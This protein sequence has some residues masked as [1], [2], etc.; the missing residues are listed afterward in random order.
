MAK[1]AL[2]IYYI[3]TAYLKFKC[4]CRLYAML[5][6][7]RVTCR[8]L[9]FLLPQFVAVTVAEHSDGS[10]ALWVLIVGVNQNTFSTLETL[11]LLRSGTAIVYCLSTCY[12]I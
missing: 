6:Y 1:A 11:S 7:D 12:C 10:I 9:S 8:S 4:R 2:S 3:I 5:I